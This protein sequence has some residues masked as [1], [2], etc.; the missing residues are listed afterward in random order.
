MNRAYY[1][2]KVINF[3]N[4]DSN[5]IL[6]QLTSNHEFSLED[7][8][9]N[10]WITQIDILKSKLSDFSDAHIAFEYTIPRMGKRVDV[11]I[12]NK[13]MV[14][15][16]PEGDDSDITTK[17]EFYEPVYQYFLRCGIPTI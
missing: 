17:R 13:G 16:V 6:G 2:S 10:S 14:I 9:K 1:S 12:L 8:Q 5:S 3:L 11:I 4:D 15:F 7:L